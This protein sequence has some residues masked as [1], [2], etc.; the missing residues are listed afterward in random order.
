MFSVVIE[1]EGAAVAMGRVVGDGAVYLYL[2]DVIVIPEHRGSGLGRQVTEALMAFVE[3]A[4]GEGT[5]VGL[6]AAR[7]VAG[8]YHRYGFVERN[9]NAPGMFLPP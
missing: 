3:V 5:F 4:S 7:G 1:V 6:M 9:P 8:F 2:Q